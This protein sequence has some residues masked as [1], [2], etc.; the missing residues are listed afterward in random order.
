MELLGIYWWWDFCNFVFYFGENGD[1]IGML[2]LNKMFPTTTQEM[3]MLLKAYQVLEII[4][5]NALKIRK[6]SF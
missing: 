5:L 4:S 3:R 6:I 1:I 2:V